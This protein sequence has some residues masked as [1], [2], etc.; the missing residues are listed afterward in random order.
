[1]NSLR[2]NLAK[3]GMAI[4]VGLGLASMLACGG[5]NSPQGSTTP[6]T[7]WSGA[8]VLESNLLFN[9]RYP[10]VAV[11]DSG[12]AMA[13]WQRDSGGVYDL[14]AK[15]LL[16]ASGWQPEGTIESM[17]GNA[18]DARMAVSSSGHFMVTWSQFSVG[19]TEC[20]IN[21][22]RW[23]AGSTMDSV[24]RLNDLNVVGYFP[25][26]AMDGAGNA[27][28]SWMEANALSGRFEI[29]LS[30]F[31]QSTTTWSAPLLVSSAVAQD[32]AWPTVAMDPSGNTV[33]TWLQSADLQ[34][35]P[36]YHYACRYKVGSGWS[37]PFPIMLGTGGVAGNALAMS[38]S[39]AIAAWTETLDGGVTFQTYAAKWTAATDA[40]STPVLVSTAGV[41][42]YSPS[43]GMDAAGNA[44][45][46][47]V[48]A[49][50]SATD[51]VVSSCSSSGGWAATP[52]ILVSSA[53]VGGVKL[54]MNASGNA[55]MIWQQKDGTV[56]SMN[57]ALYA[58]ASG[59]SSSTLLESDNAG[60]A[61]SPE[62]HIGANGQAVAVWYQL[63]AS[64]VRHVYANRAK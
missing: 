5:G 19:N 41:D 11:D 62:I 1:M 48:Q 26:V 4:L 15:P 49:R 10:S 22:R 37:T 6:T 29:K 43:L 58:P 33:I 12:N 60:N 36:Y 55:A 46:A 18:T 54:S 24:L 57:G 27:C 61:F 44:L 34:N 51:L 38:A 53:N 7:A 23:K 45:V 17:D 31:S 40:I 52:K 28:V 35:G 47:W 8:Q 42:T 9:S 63:D 13:A 39:G 20:A 56:W 59:W 14:W 32:A 64:G 25:S 16:A 30:Q 3:S 2:C 50:T 21:V